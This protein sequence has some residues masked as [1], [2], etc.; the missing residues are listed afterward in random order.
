MEID[1]GVMFVKCLVVFFIS[2]LFVAGIG[3]GFDWKCDRKDGA[4]KLVG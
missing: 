3:G 2:T 1:V 4:M